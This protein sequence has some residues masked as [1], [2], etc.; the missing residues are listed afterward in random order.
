MDRVLRLEI[1]PCSLSK[2]PGDA[3]WTT[4]TGLNGWTVF[5][6]AG[7]PSTAL[8]WS[9]TIDLSGYVRDQLTFYPQSG[10]IQQGAFLAET[11]G[12]GSILYTIVS[13]TPLN[14]EEVFWQLTSQSGPGF[15]NQGLFAGTGLGTNQQNYE[16]VMFANSEIYVPNV[17]ITPN[18]IGIQQPLTSHQS[19]SLEPTAADTLYVM[20]LWT[21]FGTNMIGI[22]IPAS[23]VILPGKFDTE[24]DVEYMMRLKRSTE[25]SQQV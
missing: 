13:T 18:P 15:L 19:G 3:T 7:A 17:N 24:P 1:P 11:D 4:L 14:S 25:L 5:P 22:G 9:G 2:L 12:E 10:F 20:K 6:I 23:R 16:T 8:S 21:P